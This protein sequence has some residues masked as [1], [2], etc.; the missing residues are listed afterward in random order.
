MYQSVKFLIKGVIPTIMHN[1]QM[2]DPLN[3][4]AK[5]LKKITSK[6]VKTD[7][8]HL[9]MARIEWFAALYVDDKNRPCWPGENIE[10]MLVGAAKKNRLG[11]QTKSGLF[12]DGNFPLIYDG[13]KDANDLW[14][15][16]QFDKNPFISRVPVVVNKARV[17]R[18]RPIF[19]IWSLEFTVNYMDDILNRDLIIDFVRTSGR[20]IGLSDW[21]PKYGRFEIEMIS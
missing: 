10:A 3:T 4:Y 6:K 12:C 9:E 21:R 15:F 18:T 17:M 1:G 19:N 16:K 13:P 8:D 14:S 5:E 11:N 20:I 2:S 7:Q